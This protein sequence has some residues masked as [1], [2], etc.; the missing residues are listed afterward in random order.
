[1]ELAEKH[2]LTPSLAA[3]KRPD[4]S[5]AIYGNFYALL[6]AYLVLLYY[7]YIFNVLPNTA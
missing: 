2:G 6:A 4:V 5:N 7:T 3:L 1:M